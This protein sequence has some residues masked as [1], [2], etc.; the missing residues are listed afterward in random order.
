[1]VAVG[2]E[3]G[4]SCDATGIEKSRL[5]ETTEDAKELL[6]SE[7]GLLGGTGR[8]ARCGHAA[9][10]VQSSEEQVTETE[11]KKEKRRPSAERCD[12]RRGGKGHVAL[13]G[14]AD[15]A[16]KLATDD[17]TGLEKSRL[18][19]GLLEAVA[20]AILVVMKKVEEI[21]KE[22][23]A[24]KVVF[25]EIPRLPAV[26]SHRGK[27]GAE[28]T[29]GAEMPAND[30]ADM[31]VKELALKQVQMPASQKCKSAAILQLEKGHVALRGHAD[32]VKKPV[33]TDVADMNVEV[34]VQKQVLASKGCKSAAILQFEKKAVTWLDMLAKCQITDKQYSDLIVSYLGTIAGESKAQEC[35]H[36]AVGGEGSH[37]ARHAR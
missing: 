18:P 23:E 25:I 2:L 37:L 9:A 22:E 10:A 13:R 20:E 14:H 5:F 1:M 29:K 11:Q 33:A 8:V 4:G 3:A 15:V 30:A 32:G 6:V 16:E 35:C 34:P 17:D 36:R 24:M 12:E 19:A 7:V 26:A 28:E 27:A 31:S 21:K